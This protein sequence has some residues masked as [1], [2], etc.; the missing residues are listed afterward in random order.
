[1]MTSK[2]TSAS[3]PPIRIVLDSNLYIAAA[4]KGSFIAQFIFATKGGINPYRLYV[5]PVIL[6]EV[7]SKLEEKFGYEK[8][9]AVAYITVAYIKSILGIVT[10]LYPSQT[11]AAVERDPDDNRILECA[12]EA[13]AELLISA[14][15]DLLALKQYENCSIVHPSQLKYIFPDIFML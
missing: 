7:Q 9:K 13:N 3:P 10:L 2:T 12:L 15:R 14:D 11:V 6:Q 1:M 5:S 4:S 8:V